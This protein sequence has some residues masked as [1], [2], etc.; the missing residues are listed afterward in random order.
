MKRKK[1]KFP[2]AVTTKAGKLAPEMEQYINQWIKENSDRINKPIF[3][4]IYGT[5]K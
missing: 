4:R 5:K 1:N 3:E 2:S